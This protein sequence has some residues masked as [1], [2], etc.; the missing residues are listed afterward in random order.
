MQKLLRNSG[1]FLG[2]PA[3]LGTVSKSVN[4]GRRLKKEKKKRTELV[5]PVKKANVCD[6]TL[7]GFQKKNNVCGSVEG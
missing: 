7:S 5:L 2:N 1:Y 6:T 4:D 3:K